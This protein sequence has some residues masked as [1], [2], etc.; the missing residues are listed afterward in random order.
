[1]PLKQTMSADGWIDNARH[2]PS[3][4]FDARPDGVDVELV[5]IHAISLPP[6][7]FGT[8]CVADLFLNRL[9]HDAHDY[10][11]GLSALKVSAHFLLAR[12]GCLTQFVS[13]AARAWH[14]G[15][16]AWRGREACNDFSIGIEL[17]GCDSLAF[18]D[19]QYVALVALLTTLCTNYP[20]LG[21]DRVVGHSDI[22]PGRKTDPGPLF[23]WSRLRAGLAV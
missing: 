2:V 17:E 8:G 18:T 15:R 20:A 13:C 3:P 14:A 19:R 4:N 6:G 11:A 1:M 10:F 7:Q 16:S 22:A 9:D 23:D 21:A 12:D 5:V